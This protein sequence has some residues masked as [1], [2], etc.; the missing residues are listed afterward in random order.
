MNI[1]GDSVTVKCSSGASFLNDASC[2]GMPAPSIS[3]VPVSIPPS[4]L[5]VPSPSPV[6]VYILLLDQ[7]H[8]INREEDSHI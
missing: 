6:S 1:S 5:P 2:G 3:P 4:P 8:R 7:T